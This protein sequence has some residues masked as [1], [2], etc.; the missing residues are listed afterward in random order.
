MGADAGPRRTPQPDEVPA[1]PPLLVPEA[2]GARR[3]G[4]H[5]RFRRRGS[6]GLPGECN[7]GVGVSL[8]HGSWRHAVVVLF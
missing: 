3:A 5:P 7:A 6:R 4:R 1:P 2:R 8:H